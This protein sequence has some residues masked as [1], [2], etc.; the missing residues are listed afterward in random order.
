MDYRTKNQIFSIITCKSVCIYVRMYICMYVCIY[1][2]TYVCIYLYM[3]AHANCELGHR[4][5]EPTLRGLSLYQ[6]LVIYSTE[7]DCRYGLPIYVLFLWSIKNYAEVFC[8]PT[9]VLLCFLDYPIY[10][11]IH[12]LNKPTQSFIFINYSLVHL[13]IC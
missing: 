9:Y 6:Y 10:S 8:V 13:Y 2:H 12:Q 5:C 11:S 1:V 4:E 7:E 3:Y